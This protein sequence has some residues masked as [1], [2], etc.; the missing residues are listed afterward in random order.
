MRL[1]FMSTLFLGAC[2]GGASGGGAVPGQFNAKGEKLLEINGKH[3]VTQDMIDAV[4]RN[5]S[6]ADL[7]AAKESGKYATMVE[8]IGLGEVLYREAVDSKLYEDPEV[9]KSLAMKMRE[10]LAQ[11]LLAK[12]VQER[13]TDEAIQAMYD[14]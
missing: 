9:Q 11:E 13:I 12:R 7:E 4:T 1:V 10:A 6:A 3:Q 14:S 5:S 8:Q 2:S